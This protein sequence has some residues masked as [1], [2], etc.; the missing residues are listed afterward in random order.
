MGDLYQKYV[1]LIFKY[2]AVVAS[3][4]AVTG[5]TSKVSKA[6]IGSQG[7]Y[8]D[9]DPNKDSGLKGQ[10]K[11]WTLLIFLGI[12]V[13]GLVCIVLDKFVPQDTLLIDKFSGLTDNLF[14]FWM[15]A[16]GGVAVTG[17]I[18]TV[19]GNIK[20]NKESNIAASAT[21]IDAAVSVPDPTIQQ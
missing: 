2:W 10:G 3:G 9:P 19:R 12:C 7:D 6:V 20:G 14:E 16:S 11:L 5:I 1:D 15:V 13:V 4:V 21:G 17:A 8:V 18:D